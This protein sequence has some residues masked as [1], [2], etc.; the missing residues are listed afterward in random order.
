MQL[1]DILQPIAPS[2]NS[3]PTYYP[4]LVCR[5]Q[6]RK[7]LTILLILSQPVNQWPQ[8]LAYGNPAQVPDM[9][10]VGGVGTD[11]TRWAGSRVDPA[12]ED[13]VIKVYAPSY[14][15][16]IPDASTGGYRVPTEVTGTSYGMCDCTLPRIC[17]WYHR[18]SL[19]NI[20]CALA[21][22]TVAG[23]G[24]YLLGLSSLSN[25]LLDDDPVQRVRN[26]KDELET[27]SCISRVD[28]FCGLNNLI[29]PEKCLPDVPDDFQD[30][31]EV[32]CK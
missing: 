20:Y 13:K 15:L 17:W 25:S 14:D 6:G 5:F 24:T 2:G 30:G 23:L 8:L 16:K 9:M 12:D 7:I 26:L 29:D 22:G 3:Q 18:D 32:E 1:A 10:L 19:A 27:V 28:D 31:D 21:S 11:G 4:N